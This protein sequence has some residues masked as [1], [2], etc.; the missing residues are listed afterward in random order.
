MDKN[1][2]QKKVGDSDKH[3]LWEPQV[4]KLLVKQTQNP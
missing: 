3:A 2:F 1:N 4:N